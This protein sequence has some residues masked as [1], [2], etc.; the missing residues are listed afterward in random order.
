MFGESYGP[1]SLENALHFSFSYSVLGLLPTKKKEFTF[2]R[3]P[4]C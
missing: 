2:A 3:A 4:N 1:F